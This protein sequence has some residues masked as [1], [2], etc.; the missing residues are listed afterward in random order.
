MPDETRRVPS[1]SQIIVRDSPAWAM[2]S[3]QRNPL[4]VGAGD[5]GSARAIT[6]GRDPRPLVFVRKRV[7]YEANA[8]AFIE[9][10]HTPDYGIYDGPINGASE[11]LGDACLLQTS[12]G[13]VFG[14]P[15]L[16]QLAVDEHPV[17][18]KQ[19][20]NADEDYIIPS[21]FA[22]PN[23]EIWGLRSSVIREG[24]TQVDEAGRHKV[25]VRVALRSDP[26]GDLTYEVTGGVEF[27]GGDYAYL[28]MVVVDSVEAIFN[29]QPSG[30]LPTDPFVDADRDKRFDN[31]DL[32][33]RTITGTV[34]MHARGAWVQIKGTAW[35]NHNHTATQIAVLVN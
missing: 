27:W 10:P 28:K 31:G 35:D 1:G 34:D 26:N 16:C 21:P 13:L 11:S 18:D 20:R 9:V 6:E 32:Y 2:A 5:A 29:Y 22:P 15:V 24:F 25:W 14:P 30:K 7:L 12:S 17:K 3:S 23:R 4:M 19:G 8:G 33:Q